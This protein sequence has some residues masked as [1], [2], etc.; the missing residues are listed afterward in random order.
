MSGGDKNAF[1]AINDERRAPRLAVDHDQV[2]GPAARL[3][4]IRRNH[5]RQSSIGLCAG[6]TKV[7]FKHIGAVAKPFDFAVANGFYGKKGDEG[8]NQAQ[9]QQ[10]ARRSGARF[11]LIL[12]EDEVAAKQVAVKPM[13]ARSLK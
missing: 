3:K 6:S 2:N 12:G 7:L 1:F 13:M 9:S 4:H 10:K 8:G 11:A 5:R